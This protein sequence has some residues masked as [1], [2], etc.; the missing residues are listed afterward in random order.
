MEHTVFLCEFTTQEIDTILFLFQI[1]DFPKK[2]P[3]DVCV[4]FSTPHSSVNTTHHL[5]GFVTV[6]LEVKTNW[7]MVQFTTKSTWQ[8]QQTLLNYL[9]RMLASVPIHQIE[10]V[11]VHCDGKWNRSNADLLYC[12]ENR[13]VTL[14]NQSVVWK[15]FK[16]AMSTGST[17]SHSDRL[18]K[19]FYVHVY[20]FLIVH[21]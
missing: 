18:I 9:H 17:A 3:R 1:R 21:F 14:V 5:P 8:T 12:I 19:L 2:E 6:N 11:A 4:Y 20:L 7:A 15:A 13:G 10:P 16:W